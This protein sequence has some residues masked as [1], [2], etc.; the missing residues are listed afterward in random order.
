ML[1]FVRQMKE[2]F[3]GKQSKLVL[4]V[5]KPNWNMH[6]ST[7]LSQRDLKLLISSLEGAQSIGIE[8]IEYNKT[9][10]QSS[11]LTIPLSSFETIPPFPTSEKILN[12]PSIRSP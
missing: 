8:V 9:G 12:E 7:C 2:R 1:S 3:Q 5:S 6:V 4:H 10:E 11:L